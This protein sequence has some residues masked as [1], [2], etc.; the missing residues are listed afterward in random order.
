MKRIAVLRAEDHPVVRAGFRPL[1][2]AEDDITVDAPPAEAASGPIPI[3][4]S[5]SYDGWILMNEE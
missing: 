4:G 1:W 3:L 2:D 5:P